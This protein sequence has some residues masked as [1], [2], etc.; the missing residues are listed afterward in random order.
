M[1]YFIQIVANMLPIPYFNKVQIVPIPVP[2]LHEMRKRVSLQ[3]SI[4][5][6]NLVIVESEVT[7][8]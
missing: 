2:K 6:T 1:S 5:M 7:N 4:K 3:V 8:K